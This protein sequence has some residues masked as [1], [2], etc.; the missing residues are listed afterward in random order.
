MC[1]VWGLRDK[2]NSDC[3]LILQKEAALRLIT[4]LKPLNLK[5][6]IISD[7]KPCICIKIYYYITAVKTKILCDGNTPTFTY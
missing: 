1:H 3:I 4:L 6:F 2:S 7:G 5:R